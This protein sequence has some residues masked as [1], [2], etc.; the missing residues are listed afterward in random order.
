MYVMV[1]DS[2][3]DPRATSAGSILVT[4]MMKCSVAGVVTDG[5]FRNALEIGQLQIHAY[6]NRPLASTNLTIHQAI[7]LNGPIG[8]GDVAVLPGDVIVGDQK[9]VIVIP[10]H[11][12]DDYAHEAMEMTAFEYF[13]TA[14][15]KAS[16]AVIGLYRPRQR[17]PGRT[18]PP[19]V[20]RQAV[21]RID[22][23]TSSLR[24]CRR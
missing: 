18:M 1:I 7:E 13:V 20:R 5:G 14:E 2:C 8:C 10:L 9:G 12:V 19:G 17:R 23:S 6:H 4:R 21:R 24:P 11:L 22:P 16:A 15:I 3:K